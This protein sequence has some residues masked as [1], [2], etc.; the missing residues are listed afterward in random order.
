MTAVHDLHGG[1]RLRAGLPAAW[2]SAEMNRALSLT[3]TSL[4]GLVGS[5]GSVACK[6]A[7]STPTQAEVVGPER[8]KP[9]PVGSARVEPGVGSAIAEIDPW[10]KTAPKQKDPL[11]N[12]LFWSIAKDGK[13]SYALGT[14]HIGVDAELRLPQI[15]WDK[16]DAAPSFAMETNIGDPALASMGT[17]TKGGT[18]REELG[19]VYWKKLQDLIT[20]AT[21]NGID[22]LKPM[23]AATLLSLRGI[24][25]TPPMDG[26]LHG[27]ALNQKK[28]VIF[29]EESS[30]QAAILEK[31]MDIRM[32]KMML[33][34][35]DKGL[36]A[37]KQMTAAYLGGD[38]AKLVAL[39][40]DQKADALKAGFSAKEYD[41]SMNDLLYLRN[42]SWIMPIEKL[43]A[44]GGGFIAVGALHLVGK[45][46][47]L[48]M[49]QANGY[50]VTRIKP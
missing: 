13:T 11:P 17:R 23:I 3:V 12:P 44:A 43:H 34:D 5:L 15:V 30:K 9:E 36:E 7:P 42:A 41:A 38:A 35:P 27:R 10:L 49:L 1:F 33:D 8:A 50:T 20:P 14:M 24:P 37:T 31:W 29:L 46:S 6:Q 40:D 2:Y 18:L 45:R 47:V 21:A 28:Q 48:E 19:P 25:S 22:K 16:L 39:A 32:L 4:F 26:V